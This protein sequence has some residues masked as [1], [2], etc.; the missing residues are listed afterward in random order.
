MNDEALWI[1]KLIAWFHDPPDK[2]LELPGNEGRALKSLEQLIGG[3]AFRAIFKTD[4]SQLQSRNQRESALKDI[5]EWKT[6]KKADQIAAAMDRSAAFPGALKF[7]WIQMPRMRH[8]LS[9]RELDLG[10][11]DQTGVAEAIEKVIDEV[12]TKAPDAKSRYLILWRLMQYLLSDSDKSKLK[13]NWHLLPADSRIVDHSIWDHL[14]ATSAVAGALPQ[15][16]LLVFGIGPVQDFI[17]TARRTQD[18]WMGSYILSYL[19]WQG[20]KVIADKFG[21]D[22]MLYPS[23]RGQPLVDHWLRNEKNLPVELP[24]D[25]AL[26]RATLPNKFVALLPANEAKQAAEAVEQA[27]KDAWKILAGK[28]AEWLVNNLKIQADSFW[29]NLWNEQSSQIPECYWSIHHWPDTSTGAPSKDEADKALKVYKDLLTPRPDDPFDSIFEVFTK[30]APDLVNVGTAY[31]RLHELAQ[32]GFEARKLMRDFN[33]VVEEG[34]KCTLCGQRAALRTAKSGARDFWKD[35]SAK[36]RA[37]KDLGL[38]V[39]I[40]PDGNERLCGVCTVKRLVQRAHLQ[41]RDVLK[42]RGGFPSTSSIAAA[43]FRA[44]VIENLKDSNLATALNTH[45]SS[46]KRIGL[47]RFAAPSAFRMSPHLAR[48]VKG[49]RGQTQL[50]AIQFLCYDGDLF[51]AETLTVERLKSDYGLNVTESQASVLQASLR[52]L[53]AVCRE[54]KIAPPAKYFAILKFDG[55][56]IRDWLR[57]ENEHAPTFADMLHP[58]ARKMLDNREWEEQGRNQQVCRQWEELAAER[59]RRGHPIT[60]DEMHAGWQKFL[61][62]K[63]FL[64]PALHASLSHALANFALELAPFVVEERYCG[65]IVYAGGDDL[66]ALLPLDQVLPAARELRAFYSGQAEEN[67]FGGVDVRLTNTDL[68]GFVEFGG[69]RLMTMGTTATASIGICLAHH[70]SPLDKAIEAAR[71]AEKCA[72]NIF[73]FDDPTKTNYRDALSVIFLRRSGEEIRVGARWNYKS[74]PTDTF[75]LLAGLQRDFAEDRLSMKF[76]HAVYDQ[77]RILAGSTQIPIPNEAQEAA[78]RRL[79]IR[80]RG[81]TLNSKEAE[82][83]ARILAPPLARLAQELQRHCRGDDQPLDKAQPGMAHLAQWLQITRFLAQGGDE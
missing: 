33:P 59:T 74:L 10:A 81:A 58:E 43:S 79:L 7:D 6:A 46:L 4:A 20:M 76:A 66:L 13:A 16:A 49:L 45:L 55:D 2:M 25:E 3:D 35:V 63:R 56:R 15:P 21:P 48:L 73:G 61:K 62:G 22:V 24:S 67:P 26:T 5:E 38:Y 8:P 42:L 82:E 71:H 32:H 60:A 65:R 50:L 69:E 41:R 83:Q 77:A 53:I 30:T 37:R 18:L 47:Y 70:L 14:G 72:K 36:L 19:S 34:A 29:L 31:S 54:L 23:L 78:L 64:S 80:Q 27:V 11:L 75:D 52:R 68:A 12:K 51:Y 17:A 1:L 57:G 28:V 44:K 9:G 39:A 40:K